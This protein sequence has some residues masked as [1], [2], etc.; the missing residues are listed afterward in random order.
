MTAG[1]CETEPCAPCPP[2]EELLSAAHLAVLR[3][4][5]FA[6]KRLI[7]RARRGELLPLPAWT[8]HVNLAVEPADLDRLLDGIWDMVAAA[9]PA[10]PGLVPVLDRYV[11]DLLLAGQAHELRYLQTALA[12]AG[13]TTP[14]GPQ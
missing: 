8:R 4:L 12:T 6:G 11:R 1:P 9:L 2:C 5:E 10:H 3:A 13:L 14:G 7:T